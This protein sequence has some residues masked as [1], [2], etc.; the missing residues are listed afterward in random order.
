MGLKWLTNL[1]WFA[2]G[3]RAFTKQGYERAARRFDNRC[4]RA[5]CAGRAA[6]RAPRRAGRAGLHSG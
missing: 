4:A 1:T 6:R 5:L 3:A 2:Y